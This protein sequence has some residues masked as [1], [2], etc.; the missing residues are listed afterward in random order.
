MINRRNYFDTEEYR[1]YL[2]EVKGNSLA[3]LRKRRAQVRHL[4]EWA[5][6]IP[7]PEAHTIR[8]T[9]P[10][11]LKSARNDEKSIP[12]AVSTRKSICGVARRFLQWAKRKHSARYR[13]VTLDW[14]DT[15]RVPDAIPRSE[16]EIYTLDEVRALT[17][18]PTKRLI[19]QRAK[20]AAALLFL[21]GARVG[22]FVSLPILAIDLN[23][24]RVEQLP[25][26]GVKTKFSKSAS[27]FLLDIPDLLEVVKQWDNRVRDK[28][29]S[30]ALWY[31]TLTRDGMGF[32]GQT[33][34]GSGRRKSVA[35]SLKQLCK[36]AD[37]PY[38][39]PHSLR[40]GHAV[41]AFG[42]AK[43]PA[44]QKAISEN[45]MHDSLETTAIYTGLPEREREKRIAN[46]THTEQPASDHPPKA[47]AKAVA[48]YLTGDTEIAAVLA[49]N[50]FEQFNQMEDTS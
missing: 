21:S 15:L 19:E 44:D 36:S 16:H 9:F 50:I 8:P 2:D 34:P 20:A 48:E 17:A 27:T 5:D 7:F 18:L 13:S 14:I 28:L 39:S 4:L 6:E 46:L 10:A 1:L 45:L 31:A 42:L 22:A 38:R 37:L 30:E 32:T 33:Q 11:Y 23:K 47:I 29:P 12:L 49:K 25:R 43:N 26:L 24:R 3:T 40:H 35:Q 41:Y